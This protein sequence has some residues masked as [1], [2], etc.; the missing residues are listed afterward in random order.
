M[1][2]N[3]SA[4]EQSGQQATRAIVGA[5]AMLTVA[6]G[7]LHLVIDTAD[8]AD[9]LPR[10]APRDDVPLDALARQLACDLTECGSLYLEQLYTFSVPDGQG[11]ASINVS[12]LALLPQ[13]S[14]LSTELA[15]RPLSEAQITLKPSDRSILDYAV[16]RLQ[17]KI[18]YT[19]IAFHLMPA[20]FTLSE[21]Q[22]TY[23]TILGRTLDKRN[24]RRQML[25]SGLVSRTEAMRR[26]GSHRP[27][28]LYQFTAGHDPVAFLT[29]A[30]S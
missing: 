30:T 2:G 27:A 12:Y 17:A 1:T 4:D 5:I 25:S 7:D 19:T 16:L 8:E 28:A 24:F 21:L 26:S 23:E 10:F 11:G 22:S 20:E 9:R 6:D 15:W 13:R 3:R 14:A 18:G 29:P